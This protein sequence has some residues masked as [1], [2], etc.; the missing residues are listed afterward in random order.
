MK[1]IL[2]RKGG[3][4]GKGGLTAM[5]PLAIDS[6]S[7]G[8]TIKLLEEPRDVT[9]KFASVTAEGDGTFDGTLEQY[10]GVDDTVPVD[11]CWIIYVS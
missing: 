9:V 1:L 6:D 8:D 5:F 4:R 3:R 2:K 11:P 10:D 7:G